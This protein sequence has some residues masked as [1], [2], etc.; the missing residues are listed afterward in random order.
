[1][2]A[3]MEAQREVEVEAKGGAAAATERSR[4]RGGARRSTMR[5]R[6]VAIGGWLGESV[7]VGPGARTRRRGAA[8]TTEVTR[9]GGGSKVERASRRQDERAPLFNLGASRR[10]SAEGVS[11]RSAARGTVQGALSVSQTRVGT[12]FNFNFRHGLGGGP[13]RQR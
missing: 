7:C 6:N 3:V 11:S 9:A 13:A 2:Y 10:L 12:D 5:W 4:A 8:S 1:M